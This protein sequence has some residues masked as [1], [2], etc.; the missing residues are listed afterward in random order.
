MSKATPPLRD[1][2][3]RLIVHEQNR[4]NSSR[5]KSTDDF[6]VCERFRP[7]LA[8]LVG[9]EAFRALLASALS[10]ASAEAPAMRK[11]FVNADG[12]LEAPE[13]I[14]AQIHAD[15][16][17]EGRVVLVAQLLGLLVAFIGGKLTVRLVREIW[18][19]AALGDLQLV[20]GDN[21]ELKK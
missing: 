13:E 3:R 14:R 18:P 12:T 9:N 15:K 20:N 17:F 6:Q 16:F 11:V 21:Y 5:D 2:A 4:K 8:T 7:H 10:L 1:L 19:K